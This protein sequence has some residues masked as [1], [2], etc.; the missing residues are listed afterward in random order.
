MKQ[1]PRAKA[2][3][4]SRIPRCRDPHRSRERS[5]FSPRIGHSRIRDKKPRWVDITHESEHQNDPGDIAATCDQEHDLPA[6]GPEW[7]EIRVSEKREHRGETNGE[8]N[9]CSNSASG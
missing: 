4:P 9:D 7:L 6:R 2:G 1:V 8:K 3:A 5:L